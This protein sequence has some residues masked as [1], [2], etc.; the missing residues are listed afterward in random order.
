M[1]AAYIAVLNYAI[2]VFLGLIAIEYLVAFI[3]RKQVFYFSDTVS[4]LSSGITNILKD[5]MGLTVRVLTYSFLVEHLA[6]FHYA[7]NYWYLYVLAFL[8]KD[9]A[10]YWI[11]RLEH[12]VNIFWNR[13]LI[14]HSSEEFNLPCALR[15][16]ISEIFSYMAFFL[17]PLAILGVPAEVYA[18]VAPIHLFLQFWYHTRLI[19]KMGF[20]EKIIVTPSHHRVHHAINAIYIDKN[21]SQLF[22]FWDKWFGTF[23]EEL[24][25][26]K[27]V[28]GVKKAVNTW[29]PIWINF[30]HFFYLLRDAVF[31][32]NWK[33]KLRIWFMPTGWRPDDMQKKYPLHYI[34]VPALQ[35]KYQPEVSIYVKIF[36]LIS[37]IG[38]LLFTLYYFNHLS[39]LSTLEIAI[40]TAIIFLTVFSYTS[41][42][43]NSIWALIAEF[44]RL[45]IVL[46]LFSISANWFYFSDIYT[47]LPHI[48]F[49]GVVFAFIFTAIT[50]YKTYFPKGS[51]I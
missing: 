36:A 28:Y 16:S 27:P 2:P 15:Q 13:H 24:P 33:D 10:G 30:Q 39:K 5:V 25:E 26:E 41:L 1:K 47:Y 38:T 34:E 17:I 35:E 37:L 49:A 21:F 9:F 6:I 46:L 45:V 42:L 31:T 48:V 51:F 11:H 50:T 22:I 23:Q 19:G 40:G 29:N 12:K 8:G 7:K 20:L 44:V 3:Q 32:K 14:H 4:S 43:D 18:V